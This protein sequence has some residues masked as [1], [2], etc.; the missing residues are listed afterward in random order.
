MP[1]EDNDPPVE[2]ETSAPTSEVLMARILE[3][4]VKT[5]AKNNFKGA[6]IPA[7]AEPK[8]KTQ[9][10]LG[11]VPSAESVLPESSLPELVSPDSAKLQDVASNIAQIKLALTGLQKQQ[12]SRDQAFDLLYDELSGYKNDFYYER[13]KPTLR[14]LL[15]LLDSIE[16]FERE[17]DAYEQNGEI[18]S[19]EVVKL[20]LAHFRDQLTDALSLSELAPMENPEELFN[21]RIQRAVQV[22][23]VEAEQNNTVQRQ[24]RSGWTLGG[25]IFR[26][27]DVVVGKSDAK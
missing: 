24:I 15:F 6:K 26:P 16:E 17:I 7:A 19:H 8:A 21:P 14:L 3:P 1:N 4:R 5:N 11:Q 13:L 25:K 23:K 10:V 27:A 20:N 2:P 9:A 18:V 22:V 12:E